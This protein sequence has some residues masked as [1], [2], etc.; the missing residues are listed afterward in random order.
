MSLAWDI[1]KEIKMPVQVPMKY[2]NQKGF[3]KVYE[4]YSQLSKDGKLSKELF[5]YAVSRFPNKIGYRKLKQQ[6]L[7]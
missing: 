2:I 6:K 4:L 5:L 3:Q 7:F 1:C